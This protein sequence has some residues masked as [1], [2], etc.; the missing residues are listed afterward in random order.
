MKKIFCIGLICFLMTAF[1]GCIDNEKISDSNVPDILSSQEDI[2][3]ENEQDEEKPLKARDREIDTT[4]LFS[5]HA[6]PYLR[7]L[8]TRS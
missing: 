7:F 3:D 5:C 2:D 8:H 4:G 6:P 1:S